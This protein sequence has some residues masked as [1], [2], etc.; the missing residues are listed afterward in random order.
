MF[1]RL[2][3]RVGFPWAV[4]SIAFVALGTYVFSYLVL[5]YQPPKMASVRR[6]IDLSAL[7]DVP[8]VYTTLAGFFSGMAYYVP[9]LYIPL[10][11]NTK[12]SGFSSTR[13]ALY[14]ISIVN[15]ASIFGRIGGGILAAKMGP[16]ETYC[17]ALGCSAL[18]L[19]CW[20]AVDSTAGVIVWSVFWGLISSV[21]VSLPGAFVPI[22]CPSLAVVGTRS[23]M[24]WAAIGLGV[25][26][27]SPIAGAL[28]GNDEAELEWWRLQVFSGILML[29]S[30]I[31][32]I[33]PVLHV[34][35]R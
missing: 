35:S 22:L 24:F 12:I 33:Q 19:L 9:L 11:A 29:A 21:I 4:R 8:F 6:L 17:I 34:R 16:L 27:G 26:I 5:F 15:A 13:L 32:V 25:L 10:F 20:I 30:A 18:L 7:T 28:I 3:P 14:L 23:G 31:C 1:D 2:L